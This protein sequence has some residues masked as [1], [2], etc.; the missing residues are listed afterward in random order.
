M[1]RVGHFQ[2]TLN[3]PGLSYKESGPSA[4]VTGHPP[5]SRSPAHTPGAKAAPPAGSGRPTSGV[6][7]SVLLGVDLGQ[8]L[9]PSGPGG[10][11]VGRAIGARGQATHPHKGL[12]TSLTRADGGWG[13]GQPPQPLPGTE[14]LGSQTDPL[15][16]PCPLEIPPFKIKALPQLV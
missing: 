14:G 10:R 5:R 6:H 4:P 13:P 9:L 11:G 2:L 3:N 15:Q 16:S 1:G 7:C 8:G 12:S